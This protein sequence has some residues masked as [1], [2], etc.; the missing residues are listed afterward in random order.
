[1][2]VTCSTIAGCCSSW[3]Q[4]QPLPRAQLPA[5]PAQTENHPPTL[6]CQ[7][8]GQGN[9]SGKETERKGAL[10]GSSLT[11]IS[12]ATGSSRHMQPSKQK[13]LKHLSPKICSSQLS[14]RLLCRHTRSTG[15]SLLFRKGFPPGWPYLQILSVEFLCAVKHGAS[16]LPPGPPSVLP[17]PGVQ[18]VT[19]REKKDISILDISKTELRGHKTYL[20][21]LTLLTAGGTGLCP[22]SICSPTLSLQVELPW[23]WSS[24]F[25]GDKD[26]PCPQ[27]YLQQSIFHPA[28][29]SEA[30]RPAP[31][32]FEGLTLPPSP[33]PVLPPALSPL[34]AQG[35][36]SW[37]HQL[38]GSAGSDAG[39]NAGSSSTFLRGKARLRP[40]SAQPVPFSLLLQKLPPTTCCTLT[41][42]T[43][44]SWQ[45]HSYSIPASP[46]RWCFSLL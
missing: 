8:T 45:P 39:S 4:A 11:R 42:Q 34:C 41:I 22:T 2:S 3:F 19:A 7:H 36:V 31:L 26:R 1:M 23:P 21:P 33:L 14:C 13:P 28:P 17:F 24:S 15:M 46:Q 27:L 29:S 43:A 37:W 44:W 40:G 10:E 18:R 6:V 35:G 30:P 38:R 9:S 16:Q 25:S 20:S 32:P 12:V 5:R